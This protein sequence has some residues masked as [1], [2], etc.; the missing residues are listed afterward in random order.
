MM[1]GNN[2]YAQGGWFN[3]ENP[4]SINAPSWS[5]PAIRQPSILGALPRIAGGENSQ[6]T[7]R[8]APIHPDIFNCSLIGP[9]GHTILT[10]SSEFTEMGAY[11]HFRKDGAILATIDWCQKP[12]VVIHGIVNK[13]PI[14][15]WLSLSADRK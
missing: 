11:T 9:S 3:P 8:L 5:V 13:Q 14:S 4:H 10:V 2:P 12:T 1:Y 6:L 7:F 15:Q